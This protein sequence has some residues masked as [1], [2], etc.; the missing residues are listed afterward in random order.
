VV[1]FFSKQ[2]I[3]YLE[4]HID[5]S[6]ITSA[7]DVGCGD[8]FA[9]H[10]MEKKVSLVEG[11]DI[12]ELM[13]ANN[14]ADPERLRVIDAEALDL[15]DASYDLVYC[16]E[17]LH[18]VEDPAAAVREM[19]RVSKR[20]VLVFEPNRL[21]ILQFLF[22]LVA[23][24]DRGLLRLSKKR[25]DDLFER[26]GLRMTHFAYGGRIFP[27]RTPGWM[28]RLIGKLPFRGGRFTSISILAIGEKVVAT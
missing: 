11:G 25:M 4:E 9:N 5:F 16:W 27:N 7:F 10:Y 6:S 15:P 24:S 14:P 20:F 1:A 12:S 19:A 17:V 23:K 3:A 28:A 2:R 21:F 8:G 26:S 22:G 18:H 13:L